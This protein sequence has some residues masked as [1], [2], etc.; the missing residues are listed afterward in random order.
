MPKFGLTTYTIYVGALCNLLKHKQSLHRR[1][2]HHSPFRLTFPDVWFRIKKTTKKPGS[3][4]S[5]FFCQ[6]LPYFPWKQ[7]SFVTESHFLVLRIKKKKKCGV[8]LSE[9]IQSRSYVWEKWFSEGK[10]F[11]I[12]SKMVQFWPK[13]T[14]SRMFHKMGPTD[15]FQ[16]KFSGFSIQFG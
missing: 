2:M 8:K 15:E 10:K 6:F 11:K 12:S 4:K 3:R 13:M 1:E 9:K 16:T 5:V 14:E 7:C